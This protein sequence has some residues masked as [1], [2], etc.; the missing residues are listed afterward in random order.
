MISSIG[1]GGC[2]CD[3][4]SRVLV[5][6]GRPHVPSVR[7]CRTQTRCWPLPALPKRSN[8]H[9]HRP[10]PRRSAA[11]EGRRGGGQGRDS[12]SVSFPCWSVVCCLSPPPR[13]QTSL[14]CF[15]LLLVVTVLGSQRVSKPQRL[16]P[17]TYRFHQCLLLSSVPPVQFR[18]PSHLS[19]PKSLRSKR[20]RRMSWRYLPRHHPRP[21]QLRETGK[22]CAT[23]RTFRLVCLQ[24]YL[25]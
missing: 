19:P 5:C 17:N 10:D 7:I 18:H 22:S 24:L 3:R 14:T 2:G 13:P 8:T 6:G 21:R 9:H 12:P 25:V 20:K 23:K 15:R 4:G 1:R 11:G 16:H